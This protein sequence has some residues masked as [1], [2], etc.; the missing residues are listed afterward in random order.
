VQDV[1][2]LR[3]ADV[4]L[5]GRAADVPSGAE[6]NERDVLAELRALASVENERAV[7]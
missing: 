4:V 1:A 7:A 2:S 5:L 6:P 3:L